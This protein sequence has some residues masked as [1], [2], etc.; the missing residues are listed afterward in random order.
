LI[1]KSKEKPV[2]RNLIIIILNWN[3]RGPI[4]AKMPELYFSGEYALEERR[5]WNAGYY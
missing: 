3:I 4:L 5:D 2:L 1:E